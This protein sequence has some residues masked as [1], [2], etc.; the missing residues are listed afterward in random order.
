M[1]STKAL[2]ENDFNT[3]KKDMYHTLDLLKEHKVTEIKITNPQVAKWVYDYNPEFNFSSST[4]TGYNSIMQYRNLFEI[5]PNFKLIDLCIDQNQNF[6]FLKTLRK[7][8]PDIKLELMVN[9]PCIKGCPARV[10]HEGETFFSIYDCSKPRKRDGAMA[11]FFK[12]SAIYPWNLEYYSAIGINNFKFLP[13]HNNGLRANF[14]N[15]ALLKNYLKL[16]ENGPGDMTADEFFTST[17]S[18]TTDIHLNKNVKLSQIIPYFPK[19]EHFV[20]YGDRCM[21]SC[22]VDC[23]YCHNC[24]D[25]MEQAL[26]VKFT[27]YS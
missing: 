7:V 15:L 13:E 6:S 27:N 23:K 19:I 9:E 3:I 16:V 8:Y 21:T 24:A 22:G 25:Q 11:A 12:T 5:F 17:Y 14:N 4:A 18:Q 20:K 26:E 10:S 2:T 1:N